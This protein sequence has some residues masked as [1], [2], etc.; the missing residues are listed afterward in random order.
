[1]VEDVCV[2]NVLAEGQAYIARSA[3]LAAG[4]PVTTAASVSN[5]FCSSGL[6][7]VQNIVNQ[8]I[9]GSIDVGLAIGA[10]SMSGT[11]DNGAPQMSAKILNHSIASQNTQPM[12]QTSENVAG[13]FN[14]SRQAMDAFA[15][16]SFQKAEKAQKAGWLTD[17]IVPLSVQWR[18]P[19]TGSISTKTV[20][21]DDGIRYGT[22]AESLGK[23]R[24]AFPQW[25]PSATTGGNASQITDGAAALLLMKRFRAEA[26]GQPIMGKFCGATVSGLEPRIMGIGPTLAIP[27]ILCKMGLSSLDIDVF[28]INEAFASM[29]KLNTTQSHPEQTI[30]A[31]V[32]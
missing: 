18:D 13:K 27:K 25:S 6:L 30:I 5:R 19:K 10:E 7:A 17:E 11:P 21:R 32:V 12:G 29:V 26:L 3:V 20:D 23:I 31:D 24:A 4:F 28:E 14:I 22:T 15:A 1:L 8:I 9:S 16:S 2:G